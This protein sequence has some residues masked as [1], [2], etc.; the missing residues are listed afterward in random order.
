MS[1]KPLRVQVAEALGC[2]LVDNRVFWECACPYDE[3]QGRYV[4]GS[5]A[6]GP[7]GLEQDPEIAR[8]DTDWSATG[9]LIEKYG[10]VVGPRCDIDRFVW[11]AS[12]PGSTFS[13]PSAATPLLAVCNLILLLAKEGKLS[14]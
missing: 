5:L 13:V 6:N 4:H 1:E 14:P 2:K 12:A 9:P 3:K 10:L 7:D 11:A 8:Y